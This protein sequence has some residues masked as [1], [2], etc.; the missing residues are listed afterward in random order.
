MKIKLGIIENDVAYL[1]RIVSVFTAKY[2]DKIEIYSFTDVSTALPALA[3]S[4]IDVVVVSDALEINLS[5]IP[6]RC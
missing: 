4:K 6:K 5:L 1:N 2:S 3:G